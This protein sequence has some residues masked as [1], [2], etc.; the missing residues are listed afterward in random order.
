[1]ATA[2]LKHSIAIVVVAAAI[3]NASGA[4]AA[5]DPF[6]AHAKSALRR[7]GLLTTYLDRSAGKLLLELPK[8]VGERNECGSFLYL[9]GIRTG[10][11]S[12]PVGLD[13]GQ[14][15]DARVVTFRRVGNRVMLEQPNLRY[16]AQSADSNEVRA[17]RESFAVSILWAGEVVATASDGRLLIDLTSFVVRDAHR[18]TAALKEANQGAYSLDKDRSALEPGQCK[19]FPDNL[20]FEAVLTFASDEPGPEVRATAPTPQAITLTQHH[21]L[22]RLPDD[23]FKPRV[24]DPRCGS[25][26]VLFAD[27]AQ[28]IAADLDVRWLVRHRLEKL[29]PSAARS[30]VKWPLVYYVDSGAPEPIRSALVE[31][32]SWWA[33]AFEAAGF[34]DAFQVKLL[35]PDADPLDVRYNVIQW[36]HRASRGWSYGGGIIDPRTGEMIKGHVW[37]GSLRIRQDRMII[38]GLAGIEKSGSGLADDPVEVSLARIRQLSAHEVGHTL[39]FNHNF[40]AST[41]GDRASV[42]DYP[43]PQVG[44]RPDSS[45]DFSS[46]YGVGVG[47]W[48]V[49]TVR[50]AYSEFSSPAAEGAGLEAILRDNQSKRLL[51][52]SDE[53]TRPAGAAHPLAAM[54]D[55]GADPIATLTHELQVRRLALRRFGERNIFPGAPLGSLNA[56]LVPLYYHHRYQMEAAAKSIGGLDYSYS[57]RGDGS[58]PAR[59]VPADRQRAALAAVLTTLDPAQLDLPESLLGKLAPPSVAYPPHREFFGSHTS[60]MFDALGAAGTATELTLGVLLPP[61]RLA[62]LVDFHRRDPSQPGVEELLD[63]ITHRVF[64]DPAPATPRLRE[65]RRTQQG[66]VA[67]GLIESAAAPTQTTAVRAALEACL[68]RLAADLKRGARSGEP[69]D[70]ALR[71]ALAGD[72]ARYMARPAASSPAPSAAPGGAP[73]LPPGPPIGGWNASDECVW[74][75]SSARLRPQDYR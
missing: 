18:M 54:W 51:Y 41:Y 3:C 19:S 57:V 5:T 75:S 6:A 30:R 40:A 69:A 61:A 43:A 20:E 32:A 53:D 47:E 62:R 59:P 73:E 50:Y 38:E 4:A 12:N 36:V 58:A 71:D 46:A 14:S 1:M 29:D 55:N 10:L 21:S 45:L 34:I 49:Q 72:I 52:L 37:L 17:V 33:R 63:A 31:G 9:E 60:P 2:I 27:Y 56:V 68:T 22:V 25:F 39:G 35:P 26:E 48:D 66:V 67:R 23:G 64:G 24:W 42:M 28:P 74:E 15:G 16:R 44:I 70:R 11:G 65:I 13:R 8:P 7:T